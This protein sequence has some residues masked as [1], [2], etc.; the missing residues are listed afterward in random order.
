MAQKLN[1][2]N[3]KETIN[4]TEPVLV[5]FSSNWCGPCKVVGKTLEE[6][7]PTLPCKVYEVD[8][9]ENMELCDEYNITNIPV[10]MLFKSSEMLKKHVGLISKEEI[11]QFVK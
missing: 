1:K 7:Q 8:V 2:T 10:I 3:F 5:K 11:E 4:S 6:I 9:D